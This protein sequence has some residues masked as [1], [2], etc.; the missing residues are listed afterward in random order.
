MKY[1]LNSITEPFNARVIQKAQEQMIERVTVVPEK[2][3]QGV[4]RLNLPKARALKIVAGQFDTGCGTCRDPYDSPQP[5]EEKGA[6][7]HPSMP[8]SV[9]RMVFGS[10]RTCPKSSPPAIDLCPCEQR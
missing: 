10:W 7:A 8:A 2:R 5:G 6:L 1:L 3:A 4:E 9:V